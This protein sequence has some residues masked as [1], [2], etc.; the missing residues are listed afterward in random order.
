MEIRF[1]RDR[2]DILISNDAAKL[3]QKFPNP[4]LKEGWVLW[5][6]CITHA[7]ELIE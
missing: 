6:P 5:K 2:I 1:K 4:N 3:Q 7:A